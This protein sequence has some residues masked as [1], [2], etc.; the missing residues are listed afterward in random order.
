[1]NRIFPSFMLETLS[2]ICGFGSWCIDVIYSQHYISSFL[3]F[4]LP[5]PWWKFPTFMLALLS[6][7]IKILIFI[8][9]SSHFPWHFNWHIHAR[10]IAHIYVRRWCIYITPIELIKGGRNLQH[11]MLA[12]HIK[13]TASQMNNFKGI[14][15]TCLLAPFLII[16]GFGSWCTYG[17]Y[18]NSLCHIFHYYFQQYHDTEVL[19]FYVRITAYLHQGIYIHRWRI[20]I[21]NFMLYH[22][23]FHNI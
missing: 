1:M 18:S 22:L 20:N 5:I 14:L 4:N 11:L 2:I 15:T 13:N 8:G 12:L 23:F 21:Q 3:P 6:I 7:F 10:S 16:K 9:R 17:R 19:T